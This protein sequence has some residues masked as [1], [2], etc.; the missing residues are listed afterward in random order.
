LSG[1]PGPLAVPFSIGEDRRE[2]PHSVGEEPNLALHLPDPRLDTIGALEKRGDLT[3]A[4]FSDPL[5]EPL[6]LLHLLIG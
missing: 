6:G 1:A 4:V 3:A 5:D 2:C